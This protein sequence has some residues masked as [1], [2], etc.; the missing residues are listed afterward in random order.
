MLDLLRRY[1]R[2][3]LIP[4]F[5]DFIKKVESTCMATQASPLRQRQALLESIM[6]ESTINSSI[7]SV[8]GNLHSCVKAGMLV[9]VDLTDPLLSPDE[10]NGIF[11]V[12]LEQFRSMHQFPGGKLLALDEAHKFLTAGNHQQGLS[13]AIVDTVRMMR[14]EGIRVAISSQNPQVLAPELL[15]LVTVA[16]IHRFHSAD[17][18]TYLKS[19]I[20]LMAP[21]E[22]LESVAEGRRDAAT[23]DSLRSLPSGEAIVFSASSAVR[24]VSPFSTLRVA[25]RPRLTADRGASKLNA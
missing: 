20:P 13:R 24:G 22:E 11:E 23:L 19:K 4:N 21:D 2:D 8:G 7:R 5:G 1:Q 15:E 6:L 25:M 10:A 14:H 17:W 9:V 12:L 16:I 18:F 3:N